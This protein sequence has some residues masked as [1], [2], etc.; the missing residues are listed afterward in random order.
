MASDSLVSQLHECFKASYDVDFSSPQRLFDA[1]RN[2]LEYVM[3]L[4]R[5]LEAAMFEDM[6]NG[7][8]GPRVEKEGK[9]YRFIDHRPNS[10]HGLFG[11][12][13]YRRAYYVD[14]QG[15]SYTPLDERLGIEKKHTPGL[16]YFMSSFT[17]REAYEGSLRWFHEIFRPD[18]RD[19][20]SERKALD[21]DYELGDRLESKRQQ[22]IE[23]VY[24][25][26][27][28][29]EKERVIEGV[30]AV[31]IDATKVRVKEGEEVTEDGRKRYEIGFRDVKV[32]VVSEVL[33]D[34]VRSEA[35]CRNSSYVSG[36]EHADKFFPRMTVEMQRRCEDGSKQKIVFLADG[37]TWIWDRIPDLGKE[38]SVFVLDFFHATE[39]V[40]KLCKELYG[41][42]TEEYW[43]HFSRWKHLLL[44]GGVLKFIKELKKIRDGES[45]KSKGDLLQ[46]QIN[47]FEQYKDMMRYD[48]YLAERLPIGSGTVESC[49]KNVIGGRLKQGGMTWSEPGAKGMSQ[50]RSSLASDRFT[51]D[52]RETLKNVA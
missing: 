12:I 25:R 30:V 33:W 10:V 20:V 4:G 27:E 18:G 32:G 44:K 35:Y 19:M 36:M 3:R 8:E 40:S 52:F 46:G 49:C 1:Q 21:M 7:Y 6:G 17:G 11:M 50:I 24:E 38:N 37:A 23:A 34:E 16:N 22:E 45:R 42:Q 2:L 14:G 43:R 13:E 31:S 47:Y 9:Q 28:S 29:M 26:Q 5:D 48:V 15:G 51:T 41:E 39:H